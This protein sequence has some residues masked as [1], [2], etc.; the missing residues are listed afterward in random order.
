[1]S[2]GVKQWRFSA[3]TSSAC[4]W[5]KDLAKKAYMTRCG[6]D[7]REPDHREFRAASRCG[8]TLSGRERCGYAAMWYP[9]LA[10]GSSKDQGLSQRR[11]A[12][13]AAAIQDD[14]FGTGAG[15]SLVEK[16]KLAFVVE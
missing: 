11:L 6:V 1:M 10:G 9:R 12:N 16:R 14:K 5:P 4:T 15:V 7:I 3:S 13:A 2:A 8:P